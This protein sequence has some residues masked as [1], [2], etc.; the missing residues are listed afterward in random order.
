MLSHHSSFEVWGPFFGIDRHGTSYAVWGEYSDYPSHGNDGTV[1]V[2]LRQPGGAWGAIETPVQRA[3][4][5]LWNVLVAPNGALTLVWTS[6]LTDDHYHPN[7]TDAVV[8]AST[9][10]P[11][12]AW[13]QATLSDP[14]VLNVTAAVDGRGDVVAAWTTSNGVQ[15][16]HR[17]AGG[18]WGSVEQVFGS[19]GQDLDP[20]LVLT[21]PQVG[22]DGAGRA[23]LAW[24]AEGACQGQCGLIV[25][26]QA[27]DGTWSEPTTLVPVSSYFNFSL[28]VGATGEATIAWSVQV[29]NGVNAVVRPAGSAAWGT[30]RLIGAAAATPHAVVGPTGLSTVLWT[31]SQHVRVADHPHGGTWSKR[32]IGVSDGFGGLSS[33]PD[34]TLLAIWADARAGLA[35]IRPPNGAWLTPKHVPGEGL[36]LPFSATSAVTTGG[37]AILGWVRATGQ[38]TGPEDAQVTSFDPRHARFASVRVPESARV[39][40]RLSFAATVNAWLPT[41]VTWHFGDG[42]HTTGRHSHHRYQKPGTYRVRVTVKDTSHSTRTTTRTITVT[43]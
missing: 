3:S 7:Y 4:M 30:P 39:G 6:P 33:A 25:S 29:L 35:A 42:R 36:G 31:P 10:S 23:T 41:S 16:R 37:R 18:S 20:V 24:K 15:A 2:R 32:T 40:H 38:P 13:T 5:L 8:Y 11:S 28:A 17:S 27:S 14:G 22:L 12:G 26:G 21:E 19:P 1:R 43:R 9:R 34:G